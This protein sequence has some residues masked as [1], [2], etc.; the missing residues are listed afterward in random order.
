MNTK[1]TVRVL[2]A[3]MGIIM[4]MS[5]FTACSD[6]KDPSDIVTDDV[7]NYTPEWV[8]EPTISAQLIQPLVCPYYNENT[9]HYD[10]SYAD[11]YKIMI[12]GKIGLIG[13]DGKMLVE[14]KYDDIFAIRDGDDYL[15]VIE[16]EDSVKQ[17][18]IHSDTFKTV[19]AYK[20]YN[21]KKYEYYWNN[22]NPLFVCTES[23]KVT[24]ETFAPLL[25]EAVKGVKNRGGVYEP[26]G[27]YGLYVNLVNL[28]G[29]IYTGAGYY[30]DGLIAFE[31]NDKWGYLDSNGR[32]VIPFEYDAV[33]GY[34]ALGGKDTPYESFGGCVTVTKD[35]K[36]GV[37]SSDGEILVPMMFDSA[38]PVVEGKAFVKTQGKWGVIKVFETDGTASDITEPS[39]STTTTTTTT[40]TTEKST[41]ET[42]T[43]STT[44]STSE[45]TKESTTESTTK[46]TTETSTET[47]TEKIVYTK[48]NYKITAESLRLRES[49]SID[50]KEIY[51]LHS[52]DVVYVSE[53][54]GGW[55]KTTINGVEGWFSLKYAE[56]Y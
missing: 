29:M 6:K 42:T 3:I 28:T 38:T 52:G 13:S 49:S 45:S 14:A 8:V 12:D 4:I 10:I 7:G 43:E 22:D 40:T 11:C 39:S 35:K 37:I 2:A 5:A 46:T 33:W 31:S 32:T 50:S 41:S 24:E 44:R 47:T 30:S 27:K 17:T 1:L 48:G 26:T 23:G 55:G 54:N 19:S 51:Y 53:V 15:A 56:K 36:F 34:S 9:N 16:D 20:K 21:T 18:Y 25:P